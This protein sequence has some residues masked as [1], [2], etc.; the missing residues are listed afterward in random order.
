MPYGSGAYGSGTY[1]FSGAG[2]LLTAEWQMEWRG[3]LFGW[4]ATQLAITNLSGWLDYNL[5][6]SNLER[7]G[8]HGSFPG[9]MHAEERTIEIELTSDSD[10]ATV[11]A[12]LRRATVVDEDPAEEP[13][14]LWAGTE[15]PQVVLAKLKR[16]AIPTDYEFS[17]GYHRA[18]M[19]WVASDPRRYA[20]SESTSP[21]VGL[22]SPGIGGLVFPLTFP[23]TFGTPGI[24]GSTTVTNTGEVPTWPTYTI[25]GPVTGPIITTGGAVLRFR[26]DFDL[27][28]GQTAVI[29]TDTR[30]VLI[31]GVARRDTLNLT[32][33]V[34]LKAGVPTVVQFGGQGVYDPAAGLVVS[35]RPA[36]I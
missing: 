22:P 3:E 29:D 5:R 30:S 34:P 23:L 33:W 2:S 31:N 36:F 7:P 11:L 21:V 18:T 4:P 15:T 16:R 8:R 27:A 26:G 10:D 13:L 9:S 28:L 19:Q 14:T 24:A 17:V 1:G 32:E 25:T 35:F 12:G 20:V 6:G